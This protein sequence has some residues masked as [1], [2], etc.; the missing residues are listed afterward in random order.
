MIRIVQPLTFLV[1]ALLTFSAICLSTAKAVPPSALY[2]DVNADIPGGDF[3]GF[4]DGTWGTD[5]NWSSDPNGGV[6]T[7]GWIAG[8][9]AVFTAG[10]DP[11]ADGFILING[12]QTANSMLIEDGTMHFRSG[13]ADIGSGIVTVNAGATL[14]I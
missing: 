11:T 4:Y 1:A 13:T 8:S 12:T 5:P 7:T 10:T 14:D 3:G 9:D 6:S 2:W